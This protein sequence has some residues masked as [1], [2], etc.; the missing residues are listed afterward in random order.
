MKIKIYLSSLLHRWCHCINRDIWGDFLCPRS[1]WSCFWSW[2]EVGT[3]KVGNGSELCASSTLSTGWSMG[4][5]IWCGLCGR[6]WRTLIYRGDHYG[7]K[8]G[9]GNK[10][11]Q[12]LHR[13]AMFIYMLQTYV[14]YINSNL[15][16][17]G[18]Q[19]LRLSDF[20]RGISCEKHSI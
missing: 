15:Q 10:D 9:R 1:F 4:S 17:S 20:L 8:E 6:F 3:N 2:F 11:E 16:R 5:F 13:V 12:C 14:N 7:K 19:V 18:L